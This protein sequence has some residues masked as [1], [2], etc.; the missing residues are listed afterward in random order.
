MEPEA[1]AE[2]AA[3]ALVPDVDA[4]TP[5]ETVPPAERPASAP[6]AVADK[7]PSRPLGIPER[8]EICRN[9]GKDD[10]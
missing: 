8:P 6:K 5:P 3:T 7:E 10:S 9:F 4:A 1:W 2:A